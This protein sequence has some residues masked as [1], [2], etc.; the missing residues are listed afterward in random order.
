MALDSF[1]VGRLEALLAKKDVSIWLSPEGRNA[2]KDIFKKDSFTARVEAVDGIG[3]W[4]RLPRQPGSDKIGHTL[5]LLKWSY[6]AAAQLEA[7]ASETRQQSK[8]SIQ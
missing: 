8:E 1:S 6:L 7:E 2:I 5:L 4:L 3:L